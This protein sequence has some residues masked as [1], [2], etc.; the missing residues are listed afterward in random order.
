MN[1]YNFPQPAYDDERPARSDFWTRWH[2]NWPVGDLGTDPL[3][4]LSDNEDD[5]TAD[6][7]DA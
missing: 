5:L 3:R 1:S 2:N 4:W 6:D 7:P